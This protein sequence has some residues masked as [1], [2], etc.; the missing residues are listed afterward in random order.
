MHDLVEKSFDLSRNLETWR[1]HYSH[2]ISCIWHSRRSFC[3]RCPCGCCCTYLLI[4]SYDFIVRLQCFL[5]QEKF[6]TPEWIQR[7]EP[8]ISSAPVLVIDANLS[9]L[10]LEASCKCTS[11]TSSVWLS[12]FLTMIFSWSGCR[13]QC[14]C[15]VWARLSHKVPENRLNRHVCECYVSI[16]VNVNLK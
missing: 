6:L 10:A 3:W 15:M 9:T 14:S 16:L 7:F 4:P 5:W 8:N 12:L 11:Y 1:H 2:C 13:V